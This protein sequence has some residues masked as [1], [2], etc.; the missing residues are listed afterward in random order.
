[1]AKPEEYLHIKVWHASTG[2]YQ[3]YWKN[4]QERAAADNAPL[5]A[6]YHDG[7]RW[8]TIGQC[9]SVTQDR[10]GRLVRS[11]KNRGH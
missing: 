3:Y 7:R 6:C 2:S 4:L 5:D 11:E 9:S 8:V 10:I 1:M